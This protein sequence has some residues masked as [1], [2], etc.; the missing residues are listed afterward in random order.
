MHQRGTNSVSFNR[1]GEVSRQEIMS[2]F[3]RGMSVVAKL[4]Y[5]LHNLHNFHEMTYKRPTFCDACGGFVGI[6][7]CQWGLLLYTQWVY[8]LICVKT[9][10]FVYRKKSYKTSCRFVISLILAHSRDS[11][12]PLS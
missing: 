11:I 3:M 8:L 6:R 9:V 1:E 12:G 7:L 4:G 2:Y 10:H 5:N